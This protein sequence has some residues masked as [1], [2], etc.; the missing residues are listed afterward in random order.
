MRDHSARCDRER[1]SRF[2]DF[3][4]I[5]VRIERQLKQSRKFACPVIEQID[6]LRREIDAVLD[7]VRNR[8]SDDDGPEDGAEYPASKTGAAA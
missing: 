4:V 3:G 6:E 1:R 5:F 7:E 8:E 2:R